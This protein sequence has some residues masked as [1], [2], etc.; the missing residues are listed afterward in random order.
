MLYMNAP[1][2]SYEGV[3]V[4]RD[5]SDPRQ[6][7]YYPNRPR[8][9]TDE[10]NR[11][12]IRFLVYTED[13]DEI[14]G[15]DEAAAG[16][17]FFD[18]VLSWPEET[19]EKVAN[20]IKQDLDLDE[21]PRL[22]PLLFKAGKVK[23]IFLDRVS[24]PAEPGG[25]EPSEDWVTVLESSGVPSL[26]GENRA[27]FSVEMTK[28]A[29][30]L[31]YG[32]F[33]GFIP[34]GVI[35]ELTYVAMQRA[36][37]VK[38]EVD[39]SVVYDFV[40]DYEVDR[41]IFFNSDSEKIVSNLVEKRIIKIT[42]SLE[43]VGDEGMQGEFEAVRK[44]LT[45][46]V[47]EKFF[48]P[49]V[50]PKELADKD[51][52]GGILAF[53]SGVRLA[54][55]PI[56]FGCSKR[57]LNDNQVRELDIDYTTYRA[58]E[59]V[60]APQGHMSVFWEDFAPRITRD[61]VVTVVSGD[62][63]LWRQVEFKVLASAKFDSAHVDTIIVDVAYG[64]MDGDEPAAS[65]KR[66]SVELDAQHEEAAI[67]N[68][69]DPAVGTTVHY[70]F[71]VVLGPDAVVGDSVVLS[72]PWQVASE[73]I[74]PVNALELFEE[75]EVEFQ[76]SALLAK[77]IFPEVLV[78]LRYVEPASGWKH[79]TS[80]LL[81]A[82]GTTWRPAFRI[83][84]DAPRQVDYRCEYPRAGADP[85]DTG[86]LSTETD[87]V[88]VND[89]RRNLFPVRVM[90]ADRTNFEQLLV[91]LVYEDRDNDVR[92]TGS[93]T[94]SKED[95]NDEHKWVFHRVDPDRTRY[96]YNQVLI[97]TD[98]TVT[99][100][101]WVQSEDNTLLVGKVWASRWKPRPELVGPPL[102]ANGLEKIVVTIDYDDPAHAYHEHS[103]QV[104]TTPGPGQALDLQLRD[105]TLRSYRY[106]V[107]YVQTNGFERRLGPL[108]SSDTFLVVS[109][110]PP[111]G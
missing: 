65:A 54:T 5:Y 30:A 43:G 38:V 6:F 90:V 58:V 48:E 75:R 9:A 105:P 76:R 29:A 103:E 26:Y 47:F 82:D 27:I 8:L 81:K 35:Y 86:W 78:H 19:L 91:D 55:F 74:V 92:E 96:R 107:R 49:K 4:G 40:R 25:E 52:P 31:L 14:E 12:A 64:P 2:F 69:Y 68:W 70:K 71:T 53:L 98:G 57:Q 110:V 46:F 32:S 18:T 13:L 39:W 99:A 33:D 104:F 94:I 11:P 66:H 79:Q 100:P 44:Q 111:A 28:K 21:K 108:T 15:G 62:D 84:A 50:N 77:E 93:M 63:D 20:R 24:G 61:D 87:M 51:V 17:L 16:F 80:A 67:R 45:Q 3:V 56:Q 37:E 10:Q 88:V 22:A 73:G 101:G 89:P 1:F 59:R 60:I 23:L 85:L 95:I 7:W 34:A 36:F 83:P 41:F 72:S 106:S 97:E 42:G 109:T 102:A